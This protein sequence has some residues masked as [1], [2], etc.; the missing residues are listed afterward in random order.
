LVD[1]VGKKSYGVNTLI[2]HVKPFD[3]TYCVCSRFPTHV[4]PDPVR[5]TAAYPA[6]PASAT[7]VSVRIPFF[8]PVTVPVTR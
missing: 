5:I 3:R 2:D 1:P 7:S 6:L 8:A 4:G